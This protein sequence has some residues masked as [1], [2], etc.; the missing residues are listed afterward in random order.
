MAVTLQ[1]KR[2]VI[3]GVGFVVVVILINAA[4]SQITASLCS[5]SW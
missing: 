4:W 2:A 1:H 3:Y 5:L